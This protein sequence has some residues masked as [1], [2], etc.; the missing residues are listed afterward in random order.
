MEKCTEVAIEDLLL[1]N[2]ALRSSHW[3]ENEK[4]EQKLLLDHKTKSDEL[5][6][7]EVLGEWFMYFYH[8]YFQ[9]L[10]KVKNQILSLNKCYLGIKLYFWVLIN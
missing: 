1:L 3:Q 8:K 6:R 7:K 2:Q 9:N 5:H 4:I 10:N